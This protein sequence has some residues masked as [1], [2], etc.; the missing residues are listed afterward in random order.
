MLIVVLFA[1]TEFTMPS[2]SRRLPWR[3][4]MPQHAAEPPG[5]PDPGTATPGGTFALAAWNMVAQPP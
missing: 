1:F 3:G 5:L 4:R 2:H